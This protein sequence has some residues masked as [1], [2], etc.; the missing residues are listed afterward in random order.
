MFVAIFFDYITLDNDGIGPES[1]WPVKVIGPF[2]T[3]E[4]AEEAADF[5]TFDQY[6]HWDIFWMESE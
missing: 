2:V 4:D 1:L 6:T 3:R 5:T